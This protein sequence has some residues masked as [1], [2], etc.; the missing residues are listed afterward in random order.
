MRRLVTVVAALS[1]GLL[2]ALGCTPDELPLTVGCRELAECPLGKVCDLGTKECI[3]E[4][5][6]RMIGRFSCTLR[7]ADDPR[8]VP[9]GQFSEVTVRTAGGRFVLANIGCTINE[10]I[11]A[12]TVGISPADRSVSMWMRLTLSKARANPKVTL[13]PYFELGFESVELRTDSI[14]YATSLEGSVLLGGKLEHNGVLDGYIDAKML[15]VTDTFPAF[16]D[17]CPQGIASCGP[18]MPSV[19]G[20][21]YCI[22]ALRDTTHQ[23][24]VRECKLDQD[25]FLRPGAICVI[26]VCARACV[27]DEECTSPTKCVSE[28]A[29]GR[30]GCL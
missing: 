8:G 12:I 5:Q 29:G 4:P 2:L 13:G 16:G 25:C 11:D 15:P 17:P 3:D 10:E 19:G 27:R 24:C 26:G 7:R 30:K 6:E 18:L 20:V 22:E 23:I 1:S 9:L 28:T 21:Q 14:R